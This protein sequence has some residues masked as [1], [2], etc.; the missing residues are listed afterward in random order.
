M[1]GSSEMP[2]SSSITICTYIYIYITI[3]SYKNEMKALEPTDL[4]LLCQERMRAS[5]VGTKLTYPRGSPQHIPY[6]P[7]I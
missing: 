4:F 3:Y 7:S 2:I 1:V 5:E 6:L